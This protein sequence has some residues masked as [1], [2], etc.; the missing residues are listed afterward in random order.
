MSRLCERTYQQLPAWL[1]GTAD[2]Q[3]WA[4][5]RAH[6]SWCA[7]CAAVVFAH[8][9]LWAELEQWPT[10]TVRP[11]LDR[12]VRDALAQRECREGA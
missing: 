7:S 1:T 8:Y 12:A 2:A 10:A 4:A 9:A 3:R 11:E 6:V 5:Q